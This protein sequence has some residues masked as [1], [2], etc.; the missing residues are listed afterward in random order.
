M[1]DFD[2][3]FISS[4]NADKVYDL[5]IIGGGPAGLTA[6]LYASRYKLDTLMLERAPISGGQLTSTQWVENYPGFPEPVLGQKLARDMEAQA[7]LFG[8]QIVSEAVT[9][10]RLEGQVKEIQTD[11]NTWKARA[12]L[13]ATG[14]SPRRLGIPG[15]A[16]FSGNGVSY[17]ATCDGPFYPDK[18]VAVV[19]GG[20]SALEESLFIAKYARQVYIIHRRDSFNADPIIVERVK[21]EPRIELITNTVVDRIEFSE[22]L[23]RRIVLRGVTDNAQRDLPVDGVFIFVGQIPNTKLFEGK[24]TLEGGYIVT[25]HAYRTSSEGVW[26]V[27]DVRAASLRQVATAV[28]DGAAAAHYIHKYLM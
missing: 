4:A 11:Y 25:D 18:V 1:L 2:L 12:V 5:I 3:G 6:G 22:G 8:L 10:V 13:I 19:G 15:E 14:A 17:C 21:A 7:K 28:G 16:E 26:A 9:E 27:G 23:E 20:N 24:L